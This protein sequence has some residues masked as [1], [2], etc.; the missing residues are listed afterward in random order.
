MFFHK[1]YGVGWASTINHLVTLLQ[2]LSVRRTQ[3]EKYYGSEKT[4]YVSQLDQ[5][6]EG[7]HHTRTMNKSE[8]YLKHEERGSSDHAA[9]GRGVIVPRVLPELA[10]RV[11]R[12]VG[13]GTIG[14]DRNANKHMLS[15][16]PSFIMIPRD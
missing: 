13:R 12:V 4:Y 1:S 9:E 15:F 16:P 3:L 11:T 7:S 14:V 2:G 8:G 5:T 6:V 10:K